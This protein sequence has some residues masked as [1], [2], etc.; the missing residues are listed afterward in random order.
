MTEKTTTGRLLAWLQQ[1]SEG[2]LCALV[3]TLFWLYAAANRMLVRGALLVVRPAD[4]LATPTAYAVQ[5][6]LL[7]PVLAF[8]HYAAFRIGWPRNGRARALLIH[9]GLMLAVA[10]TARL[11]LD[12]SNAWLHYSGARMWQVLQADVIEGF[13]SPPV[14]VATG[15]DVVFQYSIA[16]A[17][18]AGVIAW[19]R[20]EKE[21]AAR[22]ALALETERTRR[23]ALRRQLD[24]HS[25]FN[26][27]NAVAAAIRPAPNT[28][29]AMIA[30]LGD[31]LRE[32]LAED[33]EL[34]TLAE[35]FSLAGRYLSLY[36]LRFPDRLKF[37][38]AAPEGSSAVL[39][40]TLLLQPLVENAALHGLE[41]GAARVDVEVRARCMDQGV[42]IEIENTVAS[43]AVVPAPAESPGIGLRNT[44]NR[45][46]THYG[47]HFEL[48][49]ERPAPDRLRLVLELPVEPLAA[50]A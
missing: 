17:L 8:A 33:K 47:P 18:I 27:L 6:L 48:H 50:G 20:F 43:D 28:A 12:A 1:R 34:S 3:A 9:L 49:F 26:T 24:P 31:L 35:E 39:V 16:L 19:H 15:L 46:I 10:L 29:I 44:W 7:A 23:M 22:A 13:A 42:S 30:A 21:S 4:F 45:L 36:A 32:S 38:I 11:A 14:A 40:P 5:Y 2:E 41:S 37:A 25:L